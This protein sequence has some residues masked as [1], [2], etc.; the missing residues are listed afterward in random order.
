MSL[1]RLLRRCL[2]A[3]L[4]LF[5]LAACAGPGGA[6]PEPAAP[7]TL[8]VV[9]LN[10]YHDKADWPKRLPLIVEQLRAL[11]PDIVA[12]QEV[13][14]T[15]TLRNQAQT[16]AAELG[17]AVQFVSTDPT[18][19]AHRYGNALLTRLPVQAQAWH[20]LQPHDDS[21]SI[22]HARLDVDG[23]PL[24]VYFTHLHWT[25]EGGAIRERQVADAL[26]FVSRTS[27]DT[28]A[29][30]LGDFNAPAG[31]PEFA[32]LRDGYVDAY[33]ARHPDADRA[34]VTTLN[35][36][37]FDYRSRIDLV[38]AQTGRF[39]I[40]DARVVLDRPGA[41]GTWPSDHFGTW[42]RLRLRP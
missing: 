37:F 36:H 23:R 41:D 20:R 6:K 4:S 35:P 14:Q 30:L 40:E 2:L 42:V 22:G 13:L 27:G 16:I 33:G 26:D 28:P 3:A 9:T 5:V 38:L 1:S 24:D 7:R 10:I 19:Q 25:L 31:A 39:E 17:Y 29:L 34:G 18:D 32:A 11:D 12:L 15:Q 21:R 8:D